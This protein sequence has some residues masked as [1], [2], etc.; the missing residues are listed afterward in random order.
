[1]VSHGNDYEARLVAAQHSKNINN[2]VTRGHSCTQCSRRK[3]KCDGKRPCSSCLKGSRAAHCHSARPATLT[4]VR[5]A[6]IT[7]QALLDRLRHY[8]SLLTANDIPFPEHVADYSDLAMTEPGTPASKTDDGHIIIQRGHP[9][10]V[11]NTIW[12]PLSDELDDEYTSYG[13]DDEI[14]D[15]Q[16]WGPATPENLIFNQWSPAVGELN[17]P[18]PTIPQILKL[19]QV[20]IDNFN[21]LIKLL[22]A[23]TVQATIHEA[24]A[25]D[26]SLNKSSK[27]LWSSIYLCAVTTLTD[28]ECITQMDEP[29]GTLLTRFAAMTQHALQ[30]AE[31]LK[32]TNPVTLQA[33]TL[34]LLASRRRMDGQSLW[35]LTGLASRLAK[36]M[37]LHREQSLKQLQPFEAEI[38]R[39][40]WWQIVIMDSRSGQLLGASS[41]ASF[42][43]TAD[44]KL[45]A[46]ISDSDL[47]PFMREALTSHEGPT[48]MLFC[49]IRCEI[50]QCMLRLR[51]CTVPPIPEKQ[52]QVIDLCE[53]KLDSLLKHCDQSIPLYLMSVF[54]GRS[55]I[56]QM[57]FSALQAN[58]NANSPATKDR[59]F[60][61][62][63][64][65]LEYDSLTISH[66]SLQGFLWHV[67]YSFPFQCLIFVLTDL[68]NRTQPGDQLQLQ[69]AWNVISRAYEDHPELIKDVKNPLYVALGNLAVKAWH[70]CCEGEAQT[71][72]LA[73]PGLLK[74]SAIST[75]Q[76][77]RSTRAP[78]NAAQSDALTQ[79]TAVEDGGGSWSEGHDDGPLR[80]MDFSQF[81]AGDLAVPWAPIEDGW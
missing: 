81:L 27:A 74:S 7:E 47:S 76:L 68:L 10:F 23:P 32:A 33:L 49:T 73:S 37:G 13:D 14:I 43:E 11:D 12:N 24:V 15:G 42:H 79:P 4:R 56:C 19:W 55:A 40:L 48:E 46:N 9:R 69:R 30:Q 66:P 65:I 78:N 16:V 35:L 17:H 28:E 58:E 39:R 38:R 25:G 70:R 3:V 50:G 8:E 44:T 6:R 64:Q 20:F 29:K 72:P 18:G 80:T 5:E 54:L 67:R 77:Q 75:L 52:Q 62:A 53:K 2:K 60:H 21:P 61:L 51:T 63:L 45:P 26:G 41:D 71:A 31:F 36:A 57:R 34:F 1:M 22:H 59:I